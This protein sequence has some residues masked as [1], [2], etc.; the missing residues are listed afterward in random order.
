M[1][2]GRLDLDRVV[3]VLGLALAAQLALGDVHLDDLGQRRHPQVVG[4]DGADRVA[5]AVVGLL[6][7]Q[8]EV[9]ALLLERLGQRVARGGDV[10]A[11]DGLVAEVDG[12]VDAERDRLADRAVG[13]LGAHRHGDDLVDGHGARLLDPHGLFDGVRVVRVEVLL[14]AAVHATVDSSRF[15]TAASGTSLTRTQIFTGFSLMGTD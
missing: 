11:G 4:H 6:A 12:A 10:G 3:A 8:D 14:A 5:L 2:A 13:G 15:W 9:G 7:E 1:T